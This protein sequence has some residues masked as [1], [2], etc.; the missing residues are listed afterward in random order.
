M[1]ALYL[2]KFNL[3]SDC[4]A[5]IVVALAVAVMAPVKFIYPTK[6][7]PFRNLSMAMMLSWI[8]LSAGSLLWSGGGARACFL[9][10]LIFPVYYVGLSLYLNFATKPEPLKE[11]FGRTVT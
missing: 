5:G 10:S 7:V 2:W 1:V 9:L 6:T 4:N 8:F 11:R 3:P